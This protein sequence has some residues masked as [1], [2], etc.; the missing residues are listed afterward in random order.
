[1]A[2]RTNKIRHDDETRAKIKTSQLLNRLQDH[3]LG[4]VDM[5]ST[6]VRAAE[7]ALRKVLP[8]LQASENKTEVT[9]RYVARLP[10]KAPTVIAWQQ[11]LEQ[12]QL[13]DITLL[14]PELKH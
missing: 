7:V 2:A 1:M 14:K 4:V 9:H 12:P 6:Q 3:A 8:D 5:S 13:A 10:E 11:Q